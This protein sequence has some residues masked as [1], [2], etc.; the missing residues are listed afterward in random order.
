MTV[1]AFDERKVIF[2]F[3]S[4]KEDA[5]FS[6]SHHTGVKKF[7]EK[8]EIVTFIHETGNVR[9]RDVIQ[10]QDITSF[11]ESPL[12]PGYHELSVSKA[13]AFIRASDIFFVKELSPRICKW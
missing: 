13:L 8:F 7:F 3:L 2:Y 6:F 4:V 11:P 12:L 9:N 5:P 1:N 10:R